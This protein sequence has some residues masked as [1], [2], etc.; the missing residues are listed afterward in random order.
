MIGEMEQ[1]TSRSDDL[2]SPHLAE[3]VHSKPDPVMIV[4]VITGVTIAFLMIRDYVDFRSSP[5]G[6]GYVFG[7]VT[8]VPYCLMRFTLSGKR[9]NPNDSESDWYFY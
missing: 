6:E 1:D 5:S 9:R 8:A 7:A 2:A 4:A 3:S